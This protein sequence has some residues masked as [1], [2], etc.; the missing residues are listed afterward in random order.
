MRTAITSGNVCEGKISSRAGWHFWS[1]DG[2]EEKIRKQPQ[3][4]RGGQA[5]KI[6]GT[7]A[8]TNAAGNDYRFLP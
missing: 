4:R 2:G 6:S 8:D 5:I 3:G 1:E 7:T